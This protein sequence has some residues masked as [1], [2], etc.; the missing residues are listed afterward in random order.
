MAI[1]FA[2]TIDLEGIS[3]ESFI[4]GLIIIEGVGVLGPGADLERNAG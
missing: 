2:G 1:N 3:E 4:S